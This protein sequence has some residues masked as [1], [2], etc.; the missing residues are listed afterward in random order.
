MK[1]ID[2]YPKS[3]RIFMQVFIVCAVLFSCSEED[4]FVDRTVAPVLLVFDEVQGYLAGGGLTAVPSVTKPV[5]VDNYTDPVI[6][7]LTAYELDKSGILDHTVGIDSIPVTGLQITFSKR[8][9]TLPIT[10]SSDTFGKIVVSTTW[11]ALGITDVET[12]ATASAARSIT[13]ALS[14][15]GEH[16]GQSFTRYSQV[17]FSKAAS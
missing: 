9:G 6:L 11:E 7:S 14:W 10:L 13:I 17:V 16:K 3:L 8:D 4:P 15:T 5:N 2:T 1:M 12:I